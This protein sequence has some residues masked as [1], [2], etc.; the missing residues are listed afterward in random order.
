MRFDEFFDHCLR[1]R[2]VVAIGISPI[3]MAPTYFL[4]NVDGLVLPP[5]QALLTLAPGA[6]DDAHDDFT[7]AWR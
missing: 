1:H 7:T 3:M 6:P 5:C 2:R 4:F